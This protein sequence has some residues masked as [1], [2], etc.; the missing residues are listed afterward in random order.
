MNRINA[1]IK[2]VWCGVAMCLGLATPAWGE[3]PS[4]EEIRSKVSFC[5]GCHGIPNYVFIYPTYHVPKLGGQKAEY[6]VKTLQ[7]YKDGTRPHPT[8]QAQAMNMSRQEMEGIADYLSTL[9][10]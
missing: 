9:G 5:L 6:I 4:E 2:V 8:M 7:A 10:E 1:G 3:P